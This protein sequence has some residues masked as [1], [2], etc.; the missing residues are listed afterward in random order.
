MKIHEL[1]ILSYYFCC[2]RNGSKKFEVRKNDRDFKSSDVLHLKEWDDNK[3]EYTGRSLLVEVDHILHGGE[4]GIEKG[5]CV[6]SIKKL[7][8]SQ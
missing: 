7:V 4:F 5:Y 2:I 1:K 8:C 6:M 3:N